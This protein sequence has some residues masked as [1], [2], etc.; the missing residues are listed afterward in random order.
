MMAIGRL[1][2]FSNTIE[3]MVEVADLT[4]EALEP[5][6]SKDG[7]VP[8]IDQL[9]AKEVVWVVDRMLPYGGLTMLRR[10][11]DGPTKGSET[12]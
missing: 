4:E 9:L 5:W 10:P 6:T 1:Y 12:R 2:A 11:V 7:N 3:N 8:S